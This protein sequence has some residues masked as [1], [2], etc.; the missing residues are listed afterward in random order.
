MSCF[1]TLLDAGLA[2]KNT[3]HKRSSQTLNL[4]DTSWFAIQGH[5]NSSQKVENKHFIIKKTLKKLNGKIIWKSFLKM[6]PRPWIGPPQRTCSESQK[7]QCSLKRKWFP[8]VFV[9]LFLFFSSGEKLQS[10]DSPHVRWGAH[11][12]TG[13][14]F[15]H[16]LH[17]LFFQFK[18]WVCFWFVCFFYLFV[19][20][21]NF[22]ANIE[23]YG[24]A[25]VQK[26]SLNLCLQGFGPPIAFSAIPDINV[27]GKSCHG[28]FTN[29]PLWAHPKHSAT[30]TKEVWQVA[31]A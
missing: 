25:T 14:H 18:F 24:I 12:G 22:S 17:L 7:M 16:D 15:S 21:Y 10:L 13:F 23:I 26:S 5:K 28:M 2:Q 31:T 11:P 20:W 9:F 3:A 8:F 1:R 30:F 19:L 6:K 29:I 4:L 27:Q